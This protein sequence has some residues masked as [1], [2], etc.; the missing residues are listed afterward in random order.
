MGAVLIGKLPGEDT[1][2]RHFEF[3]LK[4]SNILTN[5]SQKRT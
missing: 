4:N 3:Y 5:F 2:Y 1:K